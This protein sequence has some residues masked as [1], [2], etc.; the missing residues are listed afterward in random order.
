[1]R[2]SRLCGSGCIYRKPI[3]K[4]LTGLTNLLSLCILQAIMLM[5]RLQRVGRKNEPHFRM[6]VAEKTTSPRGKS[7]EV[8]GFINPKT[9]EK[10]LKQDRILYWI[11]KGAQVSDTVHNLLVS[12]RVI[13]GK[14]IAKHKIPAKQQE[15]KQAVAA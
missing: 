3:A 10:S 15:T 1:M 11:S 9:K 13:K 5:I 2:R 4:L 8:V 12:N 14:K 7:T 6:V